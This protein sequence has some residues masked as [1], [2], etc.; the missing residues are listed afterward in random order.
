[1]KI[2]IIRHADPDYSIDSLTEKG[3]IEAELLSQRL[4]KNDIKS[5]YVSPL[6]RARLTAEYTL[7]KLRREA[8]VCDWL[9]EFHAP[10]NR[11][12]REEKIIPWDWYPNDWTKEKNFFNLDKWG[13]NPIMQE[14]KVYE[15]FSS[16]INK[17]DKV[18][19]SHGYVRN[20]KVYTVASPNEDTIAFSDP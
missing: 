5:F 9:R 8:M 19:A 17:F 10:I 18:L 14:G 3:K 2:L 6:G 20:G 12:Y 1:M 16:V 7:K 15:E 11:P 4:I 13:E